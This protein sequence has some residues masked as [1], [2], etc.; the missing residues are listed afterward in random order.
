MRFGRQPD[1]DGNRGATV[2][3]HTSALPEWLE[4]EDQSPRVKLWEND[5][6]LTDVL[7]VLREYGDETTEWTV[8]EVHE[9]IETIHGEEDAISRKTVRRNLKSL[10]DYGIATGEKRTGEGSGQGRPWRYTPEN[11][12]DLIEFG[13]GYVIPPQEAAM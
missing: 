3:V 8:R 10:H 12:S 2:F 6:G 11:L 13:P 1:E 4:H 7:R 5:D 9:I